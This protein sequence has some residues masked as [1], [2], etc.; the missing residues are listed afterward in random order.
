[1]VP[2]IKTY[3]PK[4][5]FQYFLINIDVKAIRPLSGSVCQKEATG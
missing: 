1:M 4:A 5:T 3:S 2:I